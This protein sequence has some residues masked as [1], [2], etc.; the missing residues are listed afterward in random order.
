M[1]LQQKIKKIFKRKKKSKLEKARMRL[2]IFL[3]ASVFLFILSVYYWQDGY[4]NYDWGQN[5]EYIG[6]ITNTSFIDNALDGNQYTPMEAYLMGN[7]QSRI[8]F[9]LAIISS[10]MFGMS[11][12]EFRQQQW[13]K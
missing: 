5:L 8:A 9:A 6:L 3:I 12:M 2:D 10:M 11:Y 13:K 4:H 7:N 1:S